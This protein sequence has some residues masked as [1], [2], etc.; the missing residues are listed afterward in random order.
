MPQASQPIM[1]PA[2]TPE[3]K[4]QLLEILATVARNILI[5]RQ[6]AQRDQVQSQDKAA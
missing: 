6:Q 1:L 2:T 3:D 4:Q 5:R